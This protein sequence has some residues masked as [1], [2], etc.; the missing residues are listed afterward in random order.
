MDMIRATLMMGLRRGLVSN[1]YGDSA[2]IIDT[3]IDRVLA[4]VKMGRGSNGI[5]F[6]PIEVRSDEIVGPRHDG[7]G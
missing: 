4:T 1:Y 5:T 2:S 3:T 7:G 6:S